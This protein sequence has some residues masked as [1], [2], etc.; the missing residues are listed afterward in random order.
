MDGYRVPPS[1]QVA[2]IG[3]PDHLAASLRDTQVEYLRLG[4]DPYVATLIAIQLGPVTLQIASDHAHITRGQIAAERS[5][6]LFGLELAEESAR[7]NG[8]QMRQR[9]IVHLGPGAPILASVLEPIV[10]GALTFHVDALQAVLPAESLPRDQEFL[11]RQDGAGHPA[12][13][14]FMREAGMLARLDPARLELS[15][16]RRSMA[17]DALRLSM[18]AAGQPP[19]MDANFRAVRRRVALVRQAEELLAGRLGEPVYSGDLQ[20]ALGVPMRTLHNAFVAVHGLSIHRYLRLRRMHQARAALRA[21]HGSISLVKI[22]ALTHGF[23]HLGRFAR[24]YRALFGELPS[25]TIDRRHEVLLG[26]G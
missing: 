4:P 9:A 1:V 11:L 22:A 6:L 19:Q 18:A 13:A 21:G 23:W 17:E 7:V 12:L 2:S 8:F 3:D 5:A 15:S 10:W 26:A 25:E 20:E 16:V 24:E 14:S